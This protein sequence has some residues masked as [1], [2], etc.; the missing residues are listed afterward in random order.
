M[1]KRAF[2]F[3]LGFIIILFIITISNTTSALNAD[4]KVVLEREHIDYIYPDENNKLT[5]E[6]NVTCNIYKSGDEFQYVR[7]DL[8]AT[9]DWGWNPTL[10]D[11]QLIFYESGVYNI[12]LSFYVPDDVLN[13]TT[14]VIVVQGSWYAEPY[15]TRIPGWSGDVFADN[16]E[17]YVTY[18]LPEGYTEHENVLPEEDDKT[19]D[20]I[21]Q[22]IIII[23]IIIIILAVVKIVLYFKKK[24]I[25]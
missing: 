21:C 22:A 8:L 1:G 24:R 19:D 9:D 3:I 2:K 18:D 12:S 5:V 17:V 11:D 23:G 16:V 25:S 6:G 20:Y 15:G 13:R 4:V 7:V 10:S 14:N